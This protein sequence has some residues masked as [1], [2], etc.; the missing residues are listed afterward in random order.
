[1]ADTGDGPPQHPRLVELLALDQHARLELIKAISASGV[2]PG[3]WIRIDEADLTH[4]SIA[5]RDT[6]DALQQLDKLAGDLSDIP[7]FDGEHTWQPPDDGEDAWVIVSQTCELVRDARDEPWV[8]VVLLRAA[9][10]D[11]DLASWSR[12]SARFIPVDPTGKRS[13]YYADLR[14][15]AF[16]PKHLVSHLEVRHAIPTEADFEKQR[17]RTRFALRVGQRYSRTG[18]P[19]AIVERVVDPLVVAIAK[20]KKLR[21]PLDA[22]FSEWLLL[23]HAYEDDKLNLI[24]VTPHSSDSEGFRAAEDLFHEFW[25]KSLPDELCDQLDEEYSNVVALDELLLVEWISAWKL[26]LDFLT[27]GSKGDPDSPEPEG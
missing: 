14:V 26:N 10:I 24:A 25:T 17:P 21:V 27:Y 16:V 15:H 11:A 12:N 1:M 23:P 20:D 9:Q 8:Q 3:C 19:T 13:R 4:D 18:V 6:L 22:A 5:V 7:E 2:E